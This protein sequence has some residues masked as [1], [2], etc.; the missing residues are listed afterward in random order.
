MTR[1]SHI[2]DIEHRRPHVWLTSAINHLGR[3]A[4]TATLQAI[5]ILLACKSQ[6]PQ[7]IDIGAMLRGQS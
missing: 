5:S 3:D 6:V 7:P 1:V 4:D 2:H